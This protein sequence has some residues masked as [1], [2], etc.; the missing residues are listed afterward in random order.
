MKRILVADD[1][2]INRLFLKRLLE[3]NGWEVSMAEDGAEAVEQVRA[4]FHDAVILDVSMPGV[5]GIQA[6]KRIRS[7]ETEGGERCFIFALT[8]YDDDEYI[9]R[10]FEAGMDGHIKKPVTEKSLLQTL[11]EYLQES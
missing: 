4:Q 3:K 5:D 9:G 11:S 8:A 6:A 10:C 2:A 7:L 1:E